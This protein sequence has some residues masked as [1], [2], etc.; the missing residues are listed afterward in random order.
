M[1]I[2]FYY[3]FLRKSM[4][5]FLVMTCFF[6]KAQ[7]VNVENVRH[8]IDSTKGWSGQ[9]RLD[10]EIEKNN[11]SRILNFSN[12]LSIQYVNKRSSWFLIHDMDFKEVN[13]SEITNNSTQHLRYSYKLSPKISY[14]AFLQSQ[15]DKISEIKLRALIGTGL[16]FNLYKSEKY[17]FS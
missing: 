12:Q 10:T 17:N 15:S 9:V 13:S 8:E 7:I 2:Q 1:P 16:R 6:L 4:T 5:F 3:S 14:E 11:T